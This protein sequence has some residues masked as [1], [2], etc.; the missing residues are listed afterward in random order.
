M[1]PTLAAAVVTLLTASSALAQNPPIDLN[2]WTVEDINGAGPWNIDAPRQFANSTNTINTDC[3]VLYSDFQALGYLDFRLDVDPTGGD[4]DLIGFVLGWNPGDSANTTADYILVDWKKV[5]QT[6]Q[7]WGTAPVGLALSHVVGPF[8]RGYGGGPIDLWSHTGVCTELARGAVYGQQGWVHGTR[9]NFRVLFTPASVDVWVNGQHE[10]QVTGTFNIGRFGCYNYSQSKME[11]Q[12]P[13]PGSFATFGNGCSG[14]AGT[15]N[16]LATASPYVGET[17]PIILANIPPAAPALLALGLSN[18]TWGAIPLPLD[19]GL[20][21]APG[22]TALVSGNTFL[23]LN[24]LG[25]T[26]SLNLQIPGT[27]VPSVRPVMF[28]QGLAFDPQA[29]P[30]GL[31]F[32]NAGAVTIGIR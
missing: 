8:A 11:F 29:N 6:Y 16:L 13:L 28:F 2:L 7:N 20:L 4:D 15:P 17:L 18:T 1:R 32:S 5:T 26:A 22:C 3:S 31:T 23:L 30:L 9:Y 14:S 19:M 12:F 24:N 10:F 27:M 25:G 21:G